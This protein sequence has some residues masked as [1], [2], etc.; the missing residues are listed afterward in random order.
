MVILELLHL[1]DNIIVD[2]IKHKPGT[3]G[4]Q[5]KPMTLRLDSNANVDNR[6]YRVTDANFAVGDRQYIG[7]HTDANDA[8]RWIAD[9]SR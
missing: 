6:C 8:Y 2:H 4:D 3:L 7:S 9:D 1:N 5:S